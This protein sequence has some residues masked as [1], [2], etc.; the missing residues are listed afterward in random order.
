M[1]SSPPNPSEHD[2]VAKM[3]AGCAWDSPSYVASRL[4]EAGFVNVET[5]TEKIVAMVG[6]PDA[7]V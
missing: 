6:T 4:T 1:P 3:Y 5:L 2:V 7:C